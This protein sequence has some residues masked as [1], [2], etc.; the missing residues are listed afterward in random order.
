MSRDYEY[1]TSSSAAMVYLS[2]LRLMLTRL[3]KQNEKQFVTYKQK[4]AA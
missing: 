2:M 3:A 1:F 4:H